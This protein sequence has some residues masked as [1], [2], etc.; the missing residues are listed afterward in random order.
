M[1]LD[2]M[3]S[4]LAK[5]VDPNGRF[6]GTDVPVCKFLRRFALLDNSSLWDFLDAYPQVTRF[7]AVEVLR[8]SNA[9]SL[10]LVSQPFGAVSELEP[11]KS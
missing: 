3:K 7:Q 4:D 1:H 6:L 2:E 11:L 5:V 10:A 9:L 8:L